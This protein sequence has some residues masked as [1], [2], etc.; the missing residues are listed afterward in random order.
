MGCLLPQLAVALSGE[1]LRKKGKRGLFAGKTVWSMPEHFWNIH[2]I[3][4]AL[5]K[6]SSFPFPLYLETTRI[7]YRMLIA[8]HTTVKYR[9]M[10]MTTTHSERFTLAV[11]CNHS[12]KTWRS[13]LQRPKTRQS[14]IADF[15]PMRNSKMQKHKQRDVND[16][17]TD[18][19]LKH[20]DHNS[21]YYHRIRLEKLLSHSPKLPESR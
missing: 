5:Y 12:V 4:M 15:A 17:H 9:T 13:T 2:S 11:H 1:R 10:T 7:F 21:E 8:S 3:Q 6:Y 14:R 20:A 18:I 19:T 16:L